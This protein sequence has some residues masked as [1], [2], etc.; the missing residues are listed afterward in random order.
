MGVEIPASV[1]SSPG[2]R[3]MWPLLYAAW[4]DRSLNMKEINGL[5]KLAAEL[6]FLKNEDKLI[7]MG[8]SDPATPPGRERFK[9]WETEIR[10][11]AATI[12]EGHPP[13]LAEL[14]ARLGAEADTEHDPA[15]WADQLPALQALENGLGRVGEGVYRSIFDDYD[16]RVNR[17]STVVN[18]TT[19]AERLQRILD[20]EAADMM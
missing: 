1:P 12:P 17:D 11:I 9:L 10:R 5:R 15:W 7:L 16:S 3:A 13:S 4:A 8:L 2:L 6:P 14:C 20:G 19:R 18:A